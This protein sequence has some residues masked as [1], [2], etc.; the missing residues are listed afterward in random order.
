MQR[1]LG[2]CGVVPVHDV[3]RE[4]RAHSAA[5]HALNAATRASSSDVVSSTY[6]P[7]DVTAAPALTSTKLPA[8]RSSAT[9][10]RRPIAM[11]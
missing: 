8:C 3:V 10:A 2:T 4:N 5:S 7:G 9:N 1:A 11:P 6:R